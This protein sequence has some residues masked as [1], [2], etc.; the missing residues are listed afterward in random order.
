MF[1]RRVQQPLLFA[2]GPAEIPGGVT[3]LVRRFLPDRPTGIT[4]DDD[5]GQAQHANKFRET[6]SK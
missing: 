2:E 3:L 4:N 5:D 6:I 1:G